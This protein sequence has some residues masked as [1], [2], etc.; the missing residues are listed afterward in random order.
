MLGLLPRL[1]VEPDGCLLTCLIVNDWPAGRPLGIGLSNRVS[2]RAKFV[3][4]RSASRSTVLKV[5]KR[6]RKIAE[7]KTIAV[8]SILD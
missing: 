1:G 4:G 6:Y 5:C 8:I 3:P 2:E 7:S